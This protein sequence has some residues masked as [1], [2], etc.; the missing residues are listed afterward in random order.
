MLRRG[1]RATCLAP[2]TCDQGWLWKPGLW[3]WE[4][5]VVVGLRW[6]TKPLAW[7]PPI[8]EGSAL[9]SRHRVR[10][11]AGADLPGF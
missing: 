8:P 9:C 1:F 5:A 6:L 4:M 3:W 11:G 10:T 2:T 7:I